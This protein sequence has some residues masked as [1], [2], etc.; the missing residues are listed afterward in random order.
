MW[1]QETSDSRSDLSGVTGGDGSAEADVIVHSTD[2]KEIQRKGL[3][4]I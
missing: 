3:K 2:H 4:K 1:I